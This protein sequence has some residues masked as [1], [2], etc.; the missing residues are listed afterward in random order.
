MIARREVD[1]NNGF[2]ARVLIVGGALDHVRV[3]GLAVY[4]EYHPDRGRALAAAFLERFPLLAGHGAT[5][6]A[7]SGPRRPGCCAG[8]APPSAARLRGKLRPAVIG[9]PDLKFVI[10]RGREMKA[11]VERA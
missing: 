4:G 5:A 6:C 7:T 9:Q 2:S 1:A 3:H 11:S 8:R 10:P